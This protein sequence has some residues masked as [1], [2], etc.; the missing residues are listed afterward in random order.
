[1]T[2]LRALTDSFLVENKVLPDLR[3]DLKEEVAMWVEKSVQIN[4][5]NLIM[6]AA[7]MD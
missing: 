5:R 4:V 1:M 7:D 3:K 6:T 2:S